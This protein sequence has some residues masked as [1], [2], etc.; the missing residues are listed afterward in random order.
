MSANFIHEI[1]KAGIRKLTT[2]T[3]LFLLCRF[4]FSTV[5]SMLVKIKHAGFIPVEPG[6]RALPNN[7]LQLL[8]L[9]SIPVSRKINQSPGLN[10]LFLS[11]RVADQL[12]RA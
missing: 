8:Q 2:V 7:Q 12:V 10:F 11:F 4:S 5:A 1:H 6:D 9:I 3:L